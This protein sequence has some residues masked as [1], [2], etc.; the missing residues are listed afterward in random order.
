MGSR[1]EW[2]D[3]TQS[4]YLVDLFAEK[5][6]RYDYATKAIYKASITGK[7]GLVGIVT[8]VQ[9]EPG[10]YYVASGGELY[11]AAWDGVSPTAEP[12]ETIVT[13]DPDMIVNSFLVTPEDDYFLGGFDGAYCTS[14]KDLSLFEFDRNNQL[15]EVTD[16]F[17]ANVGL[18]MD[19]AQNIVYQLDPCTQELVAYDYTP[20]NGSLS[21]F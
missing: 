7:S 3:R 19:I 6:V 1:G 5:I 17:L 9:D 20:N 12:L 13:I 21:E 11:K 16:G 4:L 18:A 10:V 8:P 14:T 2:D 15:S